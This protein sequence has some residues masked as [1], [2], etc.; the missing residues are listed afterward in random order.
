MPNTVRPRA[1]APSSTI[2]ADGLGTRPP[3]MPMPT[4][5]PRPRRPSRDRAVPVAVPMAVSMAMAVAVA[6]PVAVPG[7][8]R[9]G[10]RHEDALLG[11]LPEVDRAP[12]AVQGRAQQPAADG[13]DEQTAHDAEPGQHALPRDLGRPADQQP[14]RDH[15]RGVRDRHGH[16]DG[17]GV[18][19]GTPP[20]REV[21]GDDGLAV[22]GHRGVRRAEHE[23]EQDGEQAGGGR[24]PGRRDRALQPRREAA[25]G[26]GDRTRAR[27]VRQARHRRP[28]RDA[29]ARL[30]R[31]RR[32]TDVER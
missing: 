19:C 8:R 24:E 5:V 6:V 16:P 7:C 28:G 31:E 32:R 2:S 10:R 3:A 17:E 13:G 11:G 1:M 26:T 18:A 22:A 25:H 27:Q 4:S 30:D 9:R 21:R 23:G 15:P 12:A 20:A 29:G 14:E